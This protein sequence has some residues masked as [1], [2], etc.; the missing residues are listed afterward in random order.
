M[1]IKYSENEY[2]MAKE[3][4]LKKLEQIKNKN[5]NINL[6]K[7]EISTD[8]ETSIHEIKKNLKQ[9]IFI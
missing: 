7:N 1:I 2:Q 9:M 8:S 3:K 5:N 4:E 6:P